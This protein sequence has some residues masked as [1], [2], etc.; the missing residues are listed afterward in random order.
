MFAE[1]AFLR[2]SLVAVGAGRQEA[3]VR[4]FLGVYAEVIEQ[5]VPFAEQQS[6]FADVALQDLFSTL[7]RRIV[8]PVN[9]VILR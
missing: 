3:R 9:D 5:V 2:K 8:K 4:L 7:G 1:V 6:T